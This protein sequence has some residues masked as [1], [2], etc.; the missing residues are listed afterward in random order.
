[1]RDR[2]DGDVNQARKPKGTP[3][4]GQF[5]PKSHPEST[6]TVGPDEPWSWDSMA[7]EL[8]QEETDRLRRESDGSLGRAIAMAIGNSRRQRIARQ[9]ER[10]MCTCGHALTD[11][12]LPAPDEPEPF[13]YCRDGCRCTGFRLAAAAIEPSWP[14]LTRKV[15][16]SG[17]V[18]AETWVDESGNLQDPPDGSPAERSF[19]PDGT[20]KFE[21]HYHAGFL[22]D[23]PDG[24]PALRWFHSDGTVKFEEHW[25]DGRQVS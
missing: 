6:V 14:G 2:E 21:E 20:I 5:A 7:V 4:G 1:M 19:R 25:Q 11:H 18:R 13:T 9:A 12:F 8:G 16:T 23:P 10:A 17:S 22:Q 3:T 15:E 24:S